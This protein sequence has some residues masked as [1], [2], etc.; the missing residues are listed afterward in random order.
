MEIKSYKDMDGKKVVKGDLVQV[1]WGEE[2]Y[3]KTVEAMEKKG[4][5]VLVRFEGESNYGWIMAK[6]HTR[7]TM[8][9]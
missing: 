1:I 4:H 7:K 2:T 9:E 5:L 8:K 6:R 3:V